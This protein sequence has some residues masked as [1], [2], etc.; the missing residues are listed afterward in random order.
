MFRAALLFTWTLFAAEVL[1]TGSMIVARD[2]G[3]DAAGRGLARGLG[4]VGL[5][6]VLIAGAGLFF[7]GRSH[8]WLGLIASSLPLL[9]PIVLFFGSTIEGELHNV[10]VQI[11]NR[12][13]TKFPTREQSQLAEAILLRDPVAISKI[14]S[15]RP[16]VNGR[17]RGGFSLLGIAIRGMNSFGTNEGSGDGLEPI[18]LLLEAGA[19]PNQVIDPYGSSALGALSVHLT[20]AGAAQ[21]F[22][23]L[24]EHG[25]NPNTEKVLLN[26]WEN[27]E[28]LRALLDHGADTAVR[29]SDGNPALIFFLYNG[30]WNAALELLRRGADTHVTGYNGMTAQSALQMVKERMES[31]RD[32]LPPEYFQIEKL[33]NSQQGK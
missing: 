14:L 12:S 5:A 3:T 26:A 30:R 24:L 22:R 20:D 9:V 2:M 16:D 29:D 21:A 1:F 25:A 33:L 10:R 6:F 7:S 13:Y 11:S 18:R 8:S 32:P 23:L 15:T 31:T 28:S 19:D 4:L 17:N 27:P